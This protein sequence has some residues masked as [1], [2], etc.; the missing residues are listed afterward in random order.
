LSNILG[1]IVFCKPHTGLALFQLDFAAFWL[2]SCFVFMS[3]WIQ[4]SS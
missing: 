2:D 4:I 1:H 3:F